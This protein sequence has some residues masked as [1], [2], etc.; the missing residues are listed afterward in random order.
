MHTDVAVSRLRS[1]GFYMLSVLSAV[2][3]LIFCICL[4]SSTIVCLNLQDFMLDIWHKHNYISSLSHIKT[5][6]FVLLGYCLTKQILQALFRL[7]ISDNV[8]KPLH[9]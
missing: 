3:R 2:Y 1:E 5:Y 9:L 6:L 7:F 8:N 4:K